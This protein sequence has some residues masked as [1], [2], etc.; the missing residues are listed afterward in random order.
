MH[1]A[2]EKE[3]NRDV[4]RQHIG[5]PHD[6]TGDLICWK[7][8]APFGPVRAHVRLGNPVQA[9]Y[10]LLVSEHD[11]TCPLNPDTVTQHIAHG[12]H[13]LADADARGIL[14]LN[15]PRQLDEVP[16][17]VRPDEDVAGIDVVRHTVTTVKPLL[18][19]AVS[20][21]AKIAQFLQ[22]HDM[23]EEITS[24]FLV[25]PHNGRLI[26]W[27]DFC[28]GPHHASYTRLFTRLRVTPVLA[29]PVAVLGTVERVSRDSNG[30]P[31]ILLA[32]NIPAP[33]GQFHVTI[34]SRF[35]SL[36]DP[37]SVGTHVLAVG[38]WEI[39]H[40][41]R[42]P[43]VRLW[44][45]AHW[46]IAFWLQNEDGTATPARC[47][48]PVSAEQHALEKWRKRPPRAGHPQGPARPV[49][50]PHPSPTAP[51]PS[52]CPAPMPPLPAASAPQAAAAA[53]LVPERTEP[54]EDAPREPTTVA[55]ERPSSPVPPMPSEPPAPITIAA[56]TVGGGPERRP[57]VMS[58]L[59]RR[60]RRA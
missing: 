57:G 55:E 45:D 34:R 5:P 53:D 32:T 16:Q 8:T 28:Y 44:T 37:L 6:F 41:G 20:T 15:L 13:G 25:R 19:P 48:E 29:H 35:A 59:R 2:R 9:Q 3:T 23:E 30:T 31:F 54:A 58:W 38:G 12:S 24:R 51:E 40:G 17:P 33:A 11:A 60:R 1:R 22:L 21:A 26:P 7:C 39:F 18:P 56:T 10:R 27:T 14:R 47:P 50:K 49:S 4:F 52:P 43:A 36:M 42:T 46:Q